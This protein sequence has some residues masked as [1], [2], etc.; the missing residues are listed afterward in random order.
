MPRLNLNDSFISLSSLVITSVSEKLKG[1]I[2]VNQSSPI[3]IEL[4]SLPPSSNEE[5]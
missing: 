3:P 1:P 2:T 4:R 5:L